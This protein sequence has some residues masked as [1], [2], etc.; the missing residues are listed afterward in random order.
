MK[1]GFI[2]LLSSVVGVFVGCIGVGRTMEKRV[3][4]K[5]HMSD[6]HLALFLLMNQWVKIKQEG[7]DIAE[8]L[9]KR[10][11]GKIAIYGMSYVGERFYEELEETDIVIAYAV[12]EKADNIFAQID[13]VTPE[14]VL[15][16]VDAIIVTPVYFFD[17][18]KQR[19]SGKIEADIISL[20]DIL[21]DL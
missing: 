12:D 19:L 18:I 16:D 14:D 21:Y 4:Q 9:K 7:K 17:E 20:E 2:A 8:Y 5:Q 6:K 3:Q 15:A 10:G 1:K 13:V 11:Y